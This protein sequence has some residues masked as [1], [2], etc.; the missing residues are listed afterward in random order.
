[1]IPVNKNYLEQLIS[2]GK[3]YLFAIRNKDY[4]LV[5]NKKKETKK[6][7]HTLYWQSIFKDIENRPKLN[8]EAEIFYR[9]ALSQE[10][11]NLLKT[12]D[13]KGKEIIK[14]YRFSKEKFIF[15]CPITL[16]FCLKSSRLN[17][18][19]NEKLSNNKSVC[20]LGIDRGEKHLA[21]YSLI[22]Q[23][24]EILDQGTLNIPFIDKDGKPRNVKAKKYLGEK[25]ELVYY[26]SL[27]CFVFI[28]GRF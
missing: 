18:E 23:E 14:N 10:N 1:L 8:G 16:N 24:G 21:Y 20:F 28:C 7:L 19:I 9:P 22:N 25:P 12:T 13:K 15:H 4:N 3:I 26:F 11:I 17:D 5:N 27:Y 6:N 2:D